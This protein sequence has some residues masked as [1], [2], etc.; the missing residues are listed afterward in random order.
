VLP[1]IFLKYGWIPRFQFPC[2]TKGVPTPFGLIDFQGGV[3]SWE[4]PNVKPA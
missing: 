4:N 2:E 3:Q 1:T